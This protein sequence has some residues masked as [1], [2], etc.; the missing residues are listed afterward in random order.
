MN[1]CLFCQTH[2]LSSRCECE[3]HTSDEELDMGFLPEEAPSTFREVGNEELF[4]A[5]LDAVTI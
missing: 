1:N 3:C 2:C 5:A 4:V